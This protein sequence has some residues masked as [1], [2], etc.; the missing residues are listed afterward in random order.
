[1]LIEDPFILWPLVGIV[2][3]IVLGIAGAGGGLIAIPM[4]IYLGGY[5]VKDATGYGLWCVSFGSIF[6][7]YV[8]RDNTHF[9]T[10]IILTVSAIICAF[11]SVSLKAASPY[12]VIVLLLN[13]AC[14]ISLYSLWIH[15][16]KES[17]VKHAPPYKSA[18]GGGIAGFLSTMTGLGGGVIMIPW[19]VTIGKLKLK[20]ASAT[21]LMVIALTAPFSLW[22]QGRMD[23]IAPLYIILLIVG[24]F[25]ASLVTKMLLKNLPSEMMNMLRKGIITLAI[26]STMIGTLAKL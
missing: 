7:W 15:K 24:V 2:S 19:M 11:I 5:S 17:R 3:G 25:L 1:M 12:W 4:L 8:Q 16:T 20:E 18:V 26:S 22:A 13:A 10:C 23:D 21:S 14:V 6:A 9:T